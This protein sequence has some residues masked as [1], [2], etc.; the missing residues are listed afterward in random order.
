MSHP[1]RDG[2]VARLGERGFLL[3]YSLV[4]FATF[5]WLIWIA[6]S[7]DD[8]EPLWIAPL[9]AWWPLSLITLLASMLLVGSFV[10][11][12]AV[13]HPGARIGLAEREP[14]GVYAITRHPMNWGIL[15]W[16]LV[17]VAAYGG[18]INLV[19]ATGMGMLA[20]LGSWGQDAKKSRLLGKPWDRW[21]ARTSFMPFGALLAGKARWAAASPGA[22]ALLGGTALWAVAH[23]LHVRA[24]G[25]FAYIPIG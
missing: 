18:A 14:T 2:L 15:L 25:P 4:S 12:P 17:H 16:A 13:P 11:N 1:M 10:K 3:A 24:A 20:L 21:R 6:R 19:I 9:W 23:W 22:V 7:F 5:G 8:G